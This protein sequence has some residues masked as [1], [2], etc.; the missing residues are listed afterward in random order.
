MEFRWG[1]KNCLAILLWEYPV[2]FLLLYLL[3]STT[4]YYLLCCKSL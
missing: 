3:A 1:E 2:F 4:Y